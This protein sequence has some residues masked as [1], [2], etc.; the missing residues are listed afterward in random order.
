[1]LSFHSYKNML[2]YLNGSGREVIVHLSI[3]IQKRKRQQY[4]VALDDIKHVMDGDMNIG[5][6]K[7]YTLKFTD[8]DGKKFKS[9]LFYVWDIKTVKIELK[10]KESWPSLFFNSYTEIL[11]YLR[12]HGKQVVAKASIWTHSSPRMVFHV[13]FDQLAEAHSSV[14]ILKNRN[15]ELLT[16]TTTDGAAHSFEQDK[17]RIVKVDSIE[18]H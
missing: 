16:F 12:S 10:P 13:D 8:V 14:L 15:K 18:I 6:Q 5:R 11:Q 17:L 7:D 9:L 4:R 3:R 2:E 1:M